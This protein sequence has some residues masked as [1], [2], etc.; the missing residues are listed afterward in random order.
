MS[1]FF[2][3]LE[4]KVSGRDRTMRAKAGKYQLAIKKDML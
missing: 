4:V 1:I 2:V 3:L